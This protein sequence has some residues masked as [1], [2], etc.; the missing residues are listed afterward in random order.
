M[1][2]RYSNNSNT[3]FEEDDNCDDTYSWNDSITEAML[4]GE[5]ITEEHWWNGIDD[6]DEE[7][8]KKKAEY[9]K[10]INE[11]EGEV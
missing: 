7:D 1:G 5:D 4:N 10:P 2:Q 8:E 6:Y 3:Y 9:N 11:M